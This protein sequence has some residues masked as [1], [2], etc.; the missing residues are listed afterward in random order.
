MK[1]ILFNIVFVVYWTIQILGGLGLAWVFIAGVMLLFTKSVAFGF[2]CIGA[3]VVG[4]WV[5]KLI[6]NSLFLLLGK[7]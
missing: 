6:A 2:L 1:G 4:G 5:L 3:S 7:L